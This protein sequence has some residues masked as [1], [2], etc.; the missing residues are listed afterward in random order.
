MNRIA[1]TAI[2]CV[3]L[4]NAAAAQ[5]LPSPQ[6]ATPAATDN[7][8][9]AAT[10]AW[11][12]SLGFGPGGDQSTSTVLIPGST[13][14]RSLAARWATT[15]NVL[16]Y[17]AK[18]DGST[19]LGA[20]LNAIAA[21]LQPNA[22][23]VIIIPAGNYALKTPVTFNGVAPVLQG[24]GFTAGPAPASGT[25]I[26]ISAPG[27][28]P[29]TFQGTN[30]RGA[31]VRDLAFRETQPGTGP[32]WVP[33]SYDYVFRVLNALGE[34]T[35][36]NVYFAGVTRGIYADN[37]GRLNIRD[38][39]G[40]F[41]TAGIEIDDCYDIPRI[42]HLH[43]WTYQSAD[44][45]VVS[46]Q[47]AN[48]DT[49]ILRRVDGIFVGDLF[50][51][52][53]RSALHFTTGANGVTTKFYVGNL[54]ADFVKYGVWIDGNGTTGQI[55]NAT[56]QHNDQTA[57]GNRLVGSKGMLINATGVVVQA[58]NWRSDMVETDAIDVEQNGNRVDIGKIWVN[59]FNSLNN[60]SPALYVADSGSNP[61][62]TVNF[63]GQ[64][65]VQNGNGGPIIN[66]SNAA[67]ART[68]LMNLPGASVDEPRFYASAAGNPVSGSAIGPDTN[69]D[70][71]LGAK[72]PTGSVR[73][74][75]Q[76]STVFRVD[77]PGPG[78]TDLLLRSGTGSASFIAESAEANAD[79][80]LGTK[81]TGSLRVQSNG[82]TSLRATSNGASDTD[83][84]V[85]AGTGSVTVSAENASGAGDLLI[86]GQGAG[87]GVRL[88]AN[89]GTVLRVDSPAGGNSDIL[90]RSGQDAVSLTVETSDSNANIVLNPKGTGTVI[91]P[92]LPGTDNSTNAASTAFVKAAISS[93][94][95]GVTSFDTRSGSITLSAGD[96]T[97]ALGFTPY[98]VSNP[99]GY[100]TSS[101]APVQSVAGRTGAVTLG[102]A[103]VSGAAPLTSPALAGT[104][105]AP[106][107]SAS[108]N[109][110][111]IATDAFVKAQGYLTA[112]P[113]TSVAGRTGAIT[114]GVADVSGAAPLASP[115]FSGAIKITAQTDSGLKLVGTQP[116]GTGASAANTY[117][118]VGSTSSSTATR[119]TTDGN[120][121]GSNNCI[122]PAA[123]TALDLFIE[124]VGTDTSMTGN[125]SR[126]RLLDVL[127]YR[128]ANNASTQI[129]N[130]ASGAGPNGSIGSG[131]TAAYTVA[132]D[133]T[134]GCLAL[135]VTPPNADTWHW[136]ARVR[137]TEVQ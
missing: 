78:D 60:G 103:D 137:S 136:A 34:V 95:T 89:G 75:A 108:D 8:N 80:Y 55:S 121:P 123:N 59:G 72:G 109:T 30:A 39:T 49:V 27:F 82:A 69:I 73:L 16:D 83:A 81:G 5:K 107:Q 64:P 10:T 54:Y 85:T 48:E 118:L 33:A 22:A 120:A 68:V 21:Q 131:S 66:S 7:S 45:S 65:F 53:A 46:W 110:A 125:V 50:T 24:Q 119:L 122:N 1:A 41:Y 126:Y 134:N 13:V 129:V 91:V 58:D 133:A 88:Q 97:G 114:L 111:A 115:A 130:G 17:G 105:T 101:G 93:M 90:V 44:P 102:V 117:I 94:A 14:P 47:E 42:Q 38:V 40:Q 79:I 15:F 43:A 32:G 124:V 71:Y 61:T 57:P 87:N 99:A 35:F 113:V 12:R 77:S 86:A 3:F 52:G 128:G 106:T 70:F 74:R 29:I 76:N 98:N 100:I 132:A 11:V 62:N 56:T 135:S 112:V 51:L 28:V 84:L 9:A 20:V 36:D 63:S 23:N 67:V 2:L 104:P 96:I 19:D 31:V 92:T 4:V 127:M 37:S 25:M 18:T 116:G 6:F 26:T